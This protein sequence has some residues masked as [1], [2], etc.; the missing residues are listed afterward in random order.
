LLEGVATRGESGELIYRWERS[1]LSITV[2]V[3]PIADEGPVAI[4]FT[5]AR[6]VDV[7]AGAHPA[8]GVTFV[9]R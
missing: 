8:L 3:D 4:E 9:R 7:P 5:S 2:D 1:A 6:A